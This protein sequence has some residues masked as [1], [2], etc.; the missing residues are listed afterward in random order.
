MSANINLGVR[1][2]L[3]IYPLLALIAGHAVSLSFAA[4]RQYITRVACVVCVLTVVADAW[5]AHPDYMAYFNQL[6]GNHPERVLAES[7]LDWGQDL[8]RL[9]QR[10]ENLGVRKVAIAYK[11]TARLESAGLPE[12]SLASAF[13][14]TTGYV[15]VSVQFITLHY[16]M[17]GSYGWLKPY[18]P[19]ER[20]GKSIFLYNIEQ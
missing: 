15:A 1:H 6:A 2:I 3:A 19:V 9:S 14:K 16:A 20:I 17:D 11:G 10:L 8:H 5:L 13:E 4:K 18:K 7:D 12:Y